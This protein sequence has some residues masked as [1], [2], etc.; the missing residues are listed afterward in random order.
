L[1]A[2]P[3]TDAAVREGR[4]SSRQAELI[5]KTATLHPEAEQ[6][7]LRAAAQGTKA[8]HDACQRVRANGEDPAAR[9]KRQRASRSFRMWTAD[10][11][12]VEGRFRLA[13]EVGGPIKQIFD[14]E[15]QRVFRE[16]RAG[17]HESHEA[18]AADVFVA[19]MLGDGTGN[20]AKHTVHV[21]ID[22]D[23]LVRGNCRDG[24]RCE[25][26]G[27]GPVNVESVRQLLGD[28]FLTAIIKHGRDINTVAHLGRYVPAEVRTAMIVGGRECDVEGCECRGYLE[29]D[30]CEIDFV[31]GG[32]TAWWNLTW[33][34]SKHHRR[35]SSGWV[36]G[37]RNPNTGKRPLRPP[38]EA[39][40]A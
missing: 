29:R 32:P 8:L 2:L 18:Y 13:P 37:P 4:L 24:E 16:R 38:G 27:V 3:D 33:L 11:G 25:I 36:L 21:V 6:R 20:G 17:A 15:T 30:H 19:R 31:A 28:A 39:T 34:C 7:L 26:P 10:D 1:E 12:M 35:K 40:A 9:A 23:A 5:A 14:D 22:H